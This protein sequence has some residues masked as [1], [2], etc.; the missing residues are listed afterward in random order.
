ML[1]RKERKNTGLFIVHGFTGTPSSGFGDL[2]IILKANKIN[3]EMP[4]LQAHHPSEDINDFDYL[5]CIEEIEEKFI[6]FKEKYENVYV[7]GFSMGGVIA[8]HLVDKFGANKLVLIAPGFKYGLV[9]KVVGK[10]F[11]KKEKDELID[12]I[13][14]EE[15]NELMLLELDGNK[16]EDNKPTLSAYLNFTKLVSFV[17]KQLKPIQIPT[18]VYISDQD[19]VIPVSSAEFIYNHVS[20]K[21]KS[22]TIVTGVGH[23]L[24]VSDLRKKIVI[25][26]LDFYFGR[27]KWLG[28]DKK[29][30]IK[31][32]KK[33]IL[34]RKQIRSSNYE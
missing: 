14:T 5:K 22:L 3:Y 13:E 31:I 29:K 4:F 34:K 10:V 2:E 8:S 1:K 30:T 20:N 25:E 11:S 32:R 6:L 7:L 18:R 15:I 12:K 28:H 27:R 26:I 9:S 21:D 23:N 16:R 33:H 19:K 17:T 24:L